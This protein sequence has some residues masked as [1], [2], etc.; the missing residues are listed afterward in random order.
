MRLKRNEIAKV[1]VQFEK[2]KPERRRG[3]GAFPLCCGCCCCC[4]C[5]HSLGALVGATAATVKR[6]SPTQSSVAGIYWLVLAS[7]AVLLVA[8]ACGSVAGMMGLILA[9]MFLPVAQLVAS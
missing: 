5:L 8:W 2:H 4:C 3:G 7:L 9:L 6:K 1:S